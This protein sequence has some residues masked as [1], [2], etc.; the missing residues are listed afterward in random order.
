MIRKQETRTRLL[1]ITIDFGAWI[2]T[3]WGG[4]KSLKGFAAGTAAP[5][6]VK[7][8]EIARAGVQGSWPT[9]NMYTGHEPG[10]GRNRTKTA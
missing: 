5:S 1:R 4:M 6:R 8:R 2:F 9:R 7:I 10:T 3:G